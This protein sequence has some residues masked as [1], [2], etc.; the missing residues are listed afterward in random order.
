MLKTPF[1][2]VTSPMFPMPEIIKGT[3]PRLTAK[4]IIFEAVFKV[5]GVDI[6]FFNICIFPL[7]ILHDKLGYRFS[8]EWQLLRY[9]VQEWKDFLII[10][11]SGD[12]NN[13]ST[14]PNGSHIF[15]DAT[16]NAKNIK[17]YKLH[18]IE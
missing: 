1:P 17:K 13:D 9:H 15:V 12:L 8:W 10:T 6:M 3:G 5:E 4:V 2:W 14:G 11:I 18:N 7:S 16:W